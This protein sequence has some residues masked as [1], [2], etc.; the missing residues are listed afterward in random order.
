MS[1]LLAPQLGPELSAATEVEK[2][3]G[4]EVLNKIRK[5]FELR[6]HPILGA[7]GKS[8]ET[9]L[10]FGF[11]FDGT[12]NNYIQADTARNHSNVARLYDC[13][14]GLSVPG[15]LP[16]S[17]DWQHK[18]E[19]YTHFFKVYVPGV[20]SPFSQVGDTGDGAQLTAGSASGAF[21]ERRIIWALIQAINNV[22]RYFLRTP[23]VTPEETD[24]LVRRIVLNK[25]A[26][27]MMTNPG[28]AYNATAN[29]QVNMRARQAFRNI[30]LRLKTAIAQHRPDPKTRK[31]L[32]VD[33]AIVKTIYVS[34]FGFSRGATESRAF[35]N[36]LQS[37]CRLDAEVHG[38]NAQMSLGGFNVEF[39][40]LGVFDTVA[41]VGAGNTLGNTFAG[42][43]LDG[44]G[45][46]ADT[47]DSLRIPPGLKCLHL[48][49]AHDLRRS[50]PVDSISV[51]G[52][53]PAGCEEIVVPGVHSDIGCGYSPGEQGKGIHPNGDDM[54]SRIPLLMMYKAAR[55][56]GVPLKLETANPTAKLRFGLKP[57]T[58]QAFNAYIET[59]K[60]IQGPIHRIMREQARKQI[61]WRLMRRITSQTPLQKTSSFLRA[62][63]FDQNDL[64]S[65]G[66]EFEQEIE[67]FKVW[68]RE[69]GAAFRPAQQKAGFDNEH[70]AE[71]EEIATWWQEAPRPVEAV[72]TFFDHYV[73]DS[74]AAFKLIPGN[75]DNAKDMQKMLAEW[76][77]ERKGSRLWEGLDENEKRAADAYAKTGK[78]PPMRTSG[79]EPFDSS[80]KSYGI[81]GKAGYLRFRKIY[82]GEDSVLLSS[83]SADDPALRPPSVTAQNG[84]NDQATA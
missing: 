49:A 11:F 26:R 63:T 48:V 80:W 31:P 29:N 53:L 23:L 72:V 2:F 84:E 42:K 24:L 69:K 54:L 73:H 30:L 51:G 61:E 6:E 76:V 9:N 75:P 35:V 58:I 12:K 8:C 59:C 1:A 7:P 16:K 10:F 44:H 43:F 82:G 55:I 25:F 4:T 83:L 47:E 14:P 20:A 37:L 78:I 79:R 64:L 41:S 13:Y 68:R 34:T 52:N 81:S 38:N 46:W 28:A 3:F 36:W 33:P 18:P 71:W 32:K 56:N 40:F 19:K 65:A 27:A 62:S 57:A 67:A 70:L 45:A 17:T 60:E 74:R 21:G 15:V 50:F 22:H 66:Q 77:K 39:D 5:K